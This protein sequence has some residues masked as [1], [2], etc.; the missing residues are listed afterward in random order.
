MPQAGKSIAGK[1]LA[2]KNGENGSTSKLVGDAI[3][4][5]ASVALAP[6]VGP[7]ADALGG[8]IGVL[9]TSAWELSRKMLLKYKAEYKTK[10]NGPKISG[11]QFGWFHV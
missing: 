10:K 3:K 4:T 6:F 8:G 1:L 2:N 7:F 9:A 5:V 11:T